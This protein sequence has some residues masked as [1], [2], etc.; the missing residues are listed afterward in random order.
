MSGSKKHMVA[1]T[2]G[3]ESKMQKLLSRT[4]AVLVCMMFVIPTGL[5]A[6]AQ[7]GTDAEMR[8]ITA[9]RQ[10]QVQEAMEGR[11]NL[12]NM[13]ELQLESGGI[14]DRAIL[15]SSVEDGW[16]GAELLP[17]TPERQEQV[18]KVLE[19]RINTIRAAFAGEYVAAS[20]QH[21]QIGE[22]LFVRYNNT[23]FRESPTGISHGQVH[24]NTRVVLRGWQ[25]VGGHFWERVEIETGVHAGRVGYIRNDLL[26]R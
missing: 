24:A 23:N 3:K 14:S 26:R 6:Q 15:P 8:P 11:T 18:Q 9:E 13:L 21:F 10:A 1:K 17:I 7:T 12:L 22:T 19:S 20:N 2:T 16:S 5:V 4:L 25:F